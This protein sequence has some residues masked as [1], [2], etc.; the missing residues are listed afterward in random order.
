MKIIR[1]E[2]GDQIFDRLHQIRAQLRFTPLLRASDALGRHSCEDDPLAQVQELALLGQREPA[3]VSRPALLRL[4][5][6]TCSVVR[7]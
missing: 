3:S 6:S 2:L 5:C 4:Q 7:S 1:A